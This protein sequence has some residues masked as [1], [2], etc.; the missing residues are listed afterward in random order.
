MPTSKCNATTKSG[1]KCQNKVS[2]RGEHCYRHSSKPAS[3]SSKASGSAITREK[4]LQ[5]GQTIGLKLRKGSRKDDLVDQIVCHLQGRNRCDGS[6]SYS[7]DYSE[8]SYS[9]DESYDTE[10]E[11]GH[12]RHHH[13]HTSVHHLSDDVV[14]ALL[15][16]K[17]SRR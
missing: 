3:K 17:K 14:D 10:D 13:R 2:K 4:L 15:S 1:S 8:Y 12:R 9:E 11:S 16:L 7:S 6:A 5:I